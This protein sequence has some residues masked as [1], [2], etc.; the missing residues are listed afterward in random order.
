MMRRMQQARP[1]V[2][3]LFLSAIVVVGC[4]LLAFGANRCG[5]GICEGPENEINCPDDCGT[6]FTPNPRRAVM[7]EDGILGW[8]DRLIDG[9]FEAGMEDIHAELE[10]FGFIPARFG[11]LAEA[12]RSGSMGVR[13]EADGNG[14]VFALR[15]K[16]DKGEDS[17]YT[18][19]ARSVGTPADVLIRAEGVKDYALNRTVQLLE[20]RPIA[21]RIG[22]EWTEVGLQFANTTGLDHGLFVIELEPNTILDVDDARMEAEHWKTPAIP[23]PT[24]SV[25]GILVPAEPVAPIHFSVLMHIEDPPELTK[26]E[27]YFWEA[28]AIFAGMAELLHD[29]GGFLTIQPEEDWPQASRFFSDG[30]TLADLSRDFGVVYSTHT[31]GPKCIGALIEAG[32]LAQL[33]CGETLDCSPPRWAEHGS[34]AVRYEQERQLCEDNL[35]AIADLIR[36]LSNKDCGDCICCEE[37]ETDMDPDT[38]VYVGNLRELLE[39]TSGTTVSDHNGNWAYEN[40]STLADKAGMRTLS[41]FKKAETQATFDVLF[42]NPWRPTHASAVDDP[43]TFFVHDPTTQVIYIPGWGQAVTRHPEFLLERLS[44]M[45]AQVISHADPNRVNTFYIVTHV[46]HFDA[47]SDA[48]YVTVDSRMGEVDRGDE[49]SRDLDFWAEAME[50]LVQPLVDAGYVRWTSLPEMGE[51]F[52][53]WE[54]DCANR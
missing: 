52:V 23:G 19:W 50:Q 10:R 18:L 7:D 9:G 37:I 25:G 49:F 31:H 17:R 39:E 4:A 34:E 33:A 16:I 3:R 48:P 46:S 40:L 12:A 43:E 54:K 38:P 1:G 24:R 53:E 44:A 2:G 21:V 26:N 35:D 27:D 20:G 5:D 22:T 32:P 45:L 14:G 29:H 6:S 30:Q 13:V 15:A 36:P 11:Q 51:L 47:E 28:T 42:T 8:I 41:A